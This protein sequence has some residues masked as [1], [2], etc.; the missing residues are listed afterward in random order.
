MKRCAALVLATA[1]A[2]E[3]ALA[4]PVELSAFRDLP[5][6]A[7]SIQITYG[8]AP[9]QKIDVFLPDGPGP[10]PVA[11]LIH[12]GCWS[13]ATA[14]REQ[15]RHLGPELTRHGIA[16]WS[17]GYRRANEAGGGYPGTYQDVRTALDRLSAEAPA[18]RLDLSRVVLVGHSAGGHLALWAVSRGSLPLENPLQGRLRFE[19]RAVI[20]LGGVGDL[21]TFV[22]FVPVLCGPGIV[23]QLAPNDRL[24]E[25][26]PATLA[27]SVGSVIMVSG[28]LD[29]LVPPW[30]GHDYVRALRGKPGVVPRLVNVPDAGHFDLVTPSAP[31][32][33]EIL[34][35]VAAVLEKR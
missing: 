6:P 32:W 2:I 8:E 21:A 28:V 7:P 26:S 24:A 35:L 14:G 19:P 9:S 11:V 29:R 17:I 34:G 15:L 31:A 27:P 16:V 12:G 25:V 4:D 10:H 13:T 1:L 5:R 33:Q 30:V 3:S 23:E 22:R 20:S 18:H